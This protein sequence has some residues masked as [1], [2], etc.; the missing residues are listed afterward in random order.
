MRRLSDQTLLDYI[1]ATYLP[2]VHAC[3]AGVKQSFFCRY[4][5][6]ARSRDLGIWAIRKHSES[7]KI[8]EKPASLCFESFGKAQKRPKYSI[9]FATPINCTPMCFMH[10][11][12]T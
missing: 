3:A 2:R 9:L 1:I 10:I 6:I 8:V 12:T 11:R 7:V 5:K 4:T